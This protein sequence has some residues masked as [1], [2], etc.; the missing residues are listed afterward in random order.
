MTP[1]LAILGLGGLDLQPA[2]LRDLR[3]RAWVCGRRTYGGDS[4]WGDIRAEFLKEMLDGANHAGRAAR[5]DRRW[6]TRPAYWVL[7]S[8]CWAQYEAMRRLRAD[9][10][11]RNC[12]P[13]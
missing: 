12:R 8:A 13:C 2:L 6:W 4:F 3:L 1:A 9:Q 10:V 11:R 5:D 7:R